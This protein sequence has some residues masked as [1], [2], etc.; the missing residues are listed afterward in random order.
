[1]HEDH[2]SADGKGAYGCLMSIDGGDNW[3]DPD[4]QYLGHERYGVDFSDGDILYI[5][6]P[7]SKVV[8]SYSSFPKPIN[9]NPIE[10]YYFYNHNEL[11]EELQGVYFEYWSK[12]DNQSHYFHA[13]IDDPGLLRHSIDGLMQVAWSGDIKEVNDGTIVSG[14]YPTFRQNRAGDVLSTGVSFYTSKDRG[15]SWRFLSTIQY[16]EG[17]NDNYENWSFDNGGYYEPTFEILANGD[18]LCV[19]R[20]GPVS[21]MHKCIS[22]D[23]GKTWSIPKPFTPNGVFPVLTRLGNNVCVLTS[24][25]PGVQLR[26]NIDGDGDVWTEPIDMVS[27]MKDDNT[28]DIYAS[29]GYTGVLPI[30]KNTFYMVYSDFKTKND[31][32][33]DRKGIIFRKIEIIKRL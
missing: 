29:C 18:F 22:K 8:D 14:I 25:R 1:M 30:D 3:I 4:K 20:T 28:F 7:T 19:M 26:F 15:R 17:E 13:T 9:P 31:N 27:F 12:K 23:S 10:G 16:Q 6:R 2:P 32:G 5:R 21:P 24:G 33:Q 11:P